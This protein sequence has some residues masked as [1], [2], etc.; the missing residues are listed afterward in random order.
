MFKSLFFSISKA[1]SDFKYQHFFQVVE[2]VTQYSSL[3]LLQIP[4]TTTLWGQVCWE[5]SWKCSRCINYH[6]PL[7]FLSICAW[8]QTGRCIV[9]LRYRY[10]YPNLPW[11]LQ[12]W[13]VGFKDLDNGTNLLPIKCQW[14]ESLIKECLSWNLIM[15][16]DFFAIPV[17]AWQVIV[18]EIQS[19][20]VMEN[21]HS[22]RL[23][24]GRPMFLFPNT[25]LLYFF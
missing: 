24:Q 12:K 7:C 2:F 21:K 18:S 17:T 1:F 8:C 25:E 14:S 10:G 5:C 4:P 11:V 23:Y 13:R 15:S 20:K 9:I 19:T 3:K 22:M 6:L 16:V